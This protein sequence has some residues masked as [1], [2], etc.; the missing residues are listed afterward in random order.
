MI[1]NKAKYALKSLISLARNKGKGPMVIEEIAIK[2]NIP[3]K[4]LE[5][6]LCE[7]KNAG[8][9]QSRKGKGGGYELQ[10]APA[11]ITMAAVMRIIDGPIAPLPCVS[12]NFY[13]ACADCADEVSCSL[14]RTLITVR[15]ANL[16]VME[17]TT[18]EE[19][20]RLPEELHA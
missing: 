3:R 4:F 18:L 5:A 13:E 11:D 2:E 12:L 1:T 7:L 9:L 8:L 16:A 15:D 19:M 20:A 14:H 17:R 6:I 10:K